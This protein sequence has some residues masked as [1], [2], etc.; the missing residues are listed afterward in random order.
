MNKEKKKLLRSIY[1]PTL[2]IFTIWIV[3]IYKLVFD[4]N[5]YSFGIFP[6]RSY[7]L[8]GIIT[9][10]LIHADFNH[11]FANTIPLLV[12]GA[13]V[14]YFYR[15]VAFSLIFFSYLITGIL[16][17]MGGRQAFHIGSSGFIYA[18]I[19]FVFLSGI[20]KNDTRLLAL[21]LLVVFLYGS[22]IWG[23][24]PFD[25]K[26]SW[27]SHLFGALT[28]ISLAFIYR[29][30]GPIRQEYQWRNHQFDEDENEN[31]EYNENEPDESNKTNTTPPLEKQEYNDSNQSKT[32]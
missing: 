31:S 9:A 12:L 8:I 25:S 24:L 5:L 3:E 4:L 23:I 17:W 18:L 29:N 7:G 21:S 2:F 27:E 16:V 20:I 22:M 6:L 1:F 11:L 15:N 14:F 10:P 26:I 13:S 32:I 19:S 28:G 30:E